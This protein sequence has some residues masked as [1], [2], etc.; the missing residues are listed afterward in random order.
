MYRVKI[1]GIRS[2]EDGVAAARLGAHAI[3]ILCGQEHPSP[4]FVEPQCASE[5]V[6]GLAGTGLDCIAV[7]VTHLN[8]PQKVMDL[9]SRTGVKGVQLHGSHPERAAFALRENFGSSIFITRVWHCSI[10][11]EPPQPDIFDAFVIDSLNV[12]TGQV[13][14]TGTLLPLAAAKRAVR[15]VHKPV[16]LAGGLTPDNVTNLINEIKPFGV[17]ANSGLKRADGFKDLLKVASFVLQSRACLE[18]F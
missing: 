9:V 4:D 6:Q 11:C 5:I 16:I 18:H 17:D 12:S 8:D 14:G 7:L 2:S 3:G 1:C 13:G 15:M 10:D